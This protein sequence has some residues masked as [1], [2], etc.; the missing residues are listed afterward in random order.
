MD[1]PAA[2]NRSVMHVTGS[3]WKKGG[4]VAP[5][6]WQ[7]AEYQVRMGFDATVV[8]LRDDDS[9]EACGI[10]NGVSYF[11]ADASVL[12]GRILYSK[13]LK[14]LLNENGAGAGL[15]HSHGLWEYQSFLAGKFAR[16]TRT[17][18]IVSTHGML[19][20]WSIARSHWKKRLIRWLFQN[21][22]LRTA[23]CLHAT[24]A[25][26]AEGIAAFGF[27]KPIAVIPIGLE[28]QEYT[29]SDPHEAL[30]SWPELRG[31]RVLLFLSRVHPVK[32]LFN[33]IEAW[34][35]LVGEFPDWQLVIAGPDEVGHTRQIRA[36]AQAASLS[37]RV[38][39]VGPV[40]GTLKASLL[41][42]AD[43]FVLPTFTENFGIVVAESLA[44][45][46]PVITTKG[47]P[48]QS[49]VD[50]QCGW[51]IDIGVEPLAEALHA[52]LALPDDKRQ[53]MARN[54]LKLVQEQHAWP[55][56]SHKMIATYDWLLGLGDRPN[57][58]VGG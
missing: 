31:K 48:W 34:A 22:N 20:P 25:K 7:L 3:L 10:H 41:T 24:A 23:R 28:M 18:L 33:L 11:T 51:W 12:P 5:M 47:A 1:P 13:G 39:F 4:G 50:Y 42:A 21:R 26:E 16:R 54:G 32:G 40:Y 49:I 9:V 27:G 8:G 52:G 38:S 30:E 45:G 46:V 17:P 43:L 15:L 29:D 36:A 57:C 53:A 2:S 19:E 37:D 35:Q 44:A 56:I 55:E 58:V 14:A 6:V